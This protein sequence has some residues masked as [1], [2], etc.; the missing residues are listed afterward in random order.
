MNWT[1]MA[2]VMAEWI[3]EPDDFAALWFGP[4]RDRF[5]FPLGFT[6]RF[7]DV[8]ALGEHERAVRRRYE[9]D[10]REL[11]ELAFHTVTHADFRIEIVGGSRTFGGGRERGYRLL[12]AQTAH[13]AVLF[14][15][16][17]TGGV[18]ERIR[19]RVL[20]PEELPGKLG[21]IVPE[22][23]AGTYPADTFPVADIRGPRGGSGRQRTPGDRLDGI[24]ARP[25]DGGAHAHLRPG[26]VTD[27]SEPWHSARWADVRDD[28]RYLLR[29]SRE[30]LTVS[31]AG[32]AHL[33]ALFGGWI[34][35]ARRR[36]REGRAAA[37]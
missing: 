11:I 20:R 4:G 2:G 33:T 24:L 5:P 6:S 22:F 32:S 29:R 9:V 17:E 16:T 35:A 7:D 14:S 27:T 10:E 12:A 8:A 25:I 13:R 34:E 3:W 26:S 37:W 30:H 28:G 23:P 18:E 1:S 21:W 19:C 15:Q 36:L 31:P